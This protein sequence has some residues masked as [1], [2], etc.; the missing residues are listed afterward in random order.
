MRIPT[1]IR[2]RPITAG[3]ALVVLAAAGVLQFVGVNPAASQTATLAAFEARSDPGTDPTSTA[4]KQA[5]VL[6]A[7][8]S[9]QGATY[10]TGG[11]SIPTV[12]AQALHF[13]DRLYIRLQWDDATKDDTT[14][15]VENF[16]DAAAIEFPAVSAATVPSICM[17]QA[18]SG[19]NIWQ[20]RADS[21]A[22]FKD[23][24]DVYPN[25]LVDMYPSKETIFYTARAAGN[26][27]ADPAQGP[28][29]TL[30]AQAFGTLSKANVQDVKGN[31]TYA[32]GKWSVV[33]E[34]QLA[35]GDVD[36]ATFAN[37]KSTDMA[38]AV[39]NGSEGD[40][41]GRK[42]VSQFLKL[43]IVGVALG[44]EKSNPAGWIAAA[45]LLVGFVGLGVGLGW[46][47]YRE[48]KR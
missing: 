15:K 46:Y 8:L 10:P 11:G 12:S 36:Q 30:V 43:S 42:S 47:G 17:G 18:G 45:A 22:G 3:V 23:P 34:R 25:A 5:P 14:T 29:Q 37:G 21:Q 48:S 40:R 6:Q 33:F 27:Y 9:F 44:G 35:G 39:W 1:V 28:T 24:A 2:R 31:G 38:I 26:P 13:Q 32:N 20:W 16:S 19:V 4:W 41:N 7:P